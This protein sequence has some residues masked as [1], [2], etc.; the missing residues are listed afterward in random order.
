MTRAD[1]EPRPTG[2]SLTPA[3]SAAHGV[4]AAL[5][6]AYL[7]AIVDRMMLSLL[8]EPI[9]ADLRLTD[10]DIGWLAGLA[11]G[12]FYTV[13]GIPL[14]RMADR[15]HRPSLIASG[16]L[17]WS[18]ATMACGLTSSFGQ[19]FAARFFVGVGE[20]CISPAA[21]SLIADSVPRSRLGRALSVY[22]LGTVVGLGIAWIVGG[23]LIHFLGSLGPLALPAIG[24]VAPWQMVFIMVGLPGVITAPLLLM[25]REPR[26]SLEPADRRRNSSSP[27]DE[28]LAAVWH[29]MRTHGRVYVSHFTGMAAVNTYGY[30]LVTWAPA[31]FARE[32]GW[33]LGR[34][35]TVLGCGI[36]IAGIG[37]TLLSGQIADRLSR[38]GADDASFRI[39]FAGT[40][41]MIPAGI[42]GP[43]TAAAWLRAALFVVPVMGLFFGVIASAPTALQLATPRAMRASVSS[44]YLFIVN[45]VAYALGPLS[46]GFLS[47]HVVSSNQHLGPALVILAVVCLPTGALS[48]RAGLAP[49]R[50]TV[51]ALSGVS[52]EPLGQP[53]E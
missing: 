11:F 29:H 14:G 48:F 32:F 40:L 42:L 4:V 7:L 47:D 20:A 46:I 51:R 17:L 1:A 6:F 33:S 34:T 23:Q 45:I 12:L 36:L 3:R 25:I 31:M 5:S 35:G 13:M 16:V 27:P 15:V 39:L 8:V 19:L 37:G 44:V 9:K 53:G 26:S 22:M 38:S 10:T 52:A 43:M 30:A 41:L 50:Q 24:L 18:L 2:M 49:F 21:Y 28:S